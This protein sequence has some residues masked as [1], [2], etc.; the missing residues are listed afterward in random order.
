LEFRFDLPRDIEDEGRTD[1][2]SV[3]RREEV[4]DAPWEGGL[5]RHRRLRQLGVKASG[6]SQ[7]SGGNVI[8]VGVNPIRNDQELRPFMADYLC[9]ARPVLD[10][11]DEIS[12]G[13][14]QRNPP[15]DTQQL[16][17][18]LCLARTPFW[19]PDRRRFPIGQVAQ[20]DVVTLSPEREDRPPHPNLYVI[21]MSPYCQQLHCPTWSRLRRSGSH[22]ATS[23]SRSRR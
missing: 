1:V 15:R 22:W 3:V 17:R 4:H 14:L 21:G 13:H 10:R 5:A 6:F 23:A 9:H 11:V 18:L 7:C 12:V 19:R 2:Q 8:W 20:H 16:G